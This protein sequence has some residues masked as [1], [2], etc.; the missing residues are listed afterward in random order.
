MLS[1]NSTFDDMDIADV[2]VL[3]SGTVYLLEG[4]GRDNLVVKVEAA[5]VNRGTFKHAKLAMK[6]VDNTGGGQVKRLT[7]AEITALKDWADFMQG[8]TNNFAAD[9]VSNFRSGSAAENLHACL[10]G[11][12]QNLW[13]KMP[14]AQLTSGN[15]MLDIRMGVGSNPPSKGIMRQ[16]ADGLN[17]D[18]GLEQLGRII[19]ADMYIGNTDRFSPEGGSSTTYGKKTIRFKALKN[20]GNLFMV[21]KTT[22]QRIS[23]SGHDFIDPNSGYKNFDMGLQDISEGYNQEWG[24][25]TLCDPKRRK[26]FVKNVVTDLETLLTPNRKAL[27]PFRKL[28]SKAEKRVAAGIKDGMALIVAGIDGHYRKAGPPA[29]VKER[30]DKFK[31]ALG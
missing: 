17:A 7:D 26:K 14:A 31:A 29:G 24:G 21:G 15:E 3:R 13:F 18:G 12:Q 28:S 23:V 4:H 9:K 16:F 11:A 6:A 19:A 5:N 25:D 2:R 1:M 20:P 8:I 27:S 30:R 22:E 10:L